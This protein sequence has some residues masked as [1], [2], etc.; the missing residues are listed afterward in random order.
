MP[1][2]IPLAGGGVLLG[3]DGHSDCHAIGGVFEL[4]WESVGQSR[5]AGSDQDTYTI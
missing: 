5:S 1:N 3:E 4:E 2:A